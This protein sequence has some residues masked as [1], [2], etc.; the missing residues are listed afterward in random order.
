MLIIKSSTASQAWRESFLRLINE[1]LETGNQKY[2]RDEPAVIEI[3]R[4][5]LEKADPLFP[6]SQEDLDIINSFIWSG[7]NEAE[8]AHE[9]TKLYYHRAFDQPN[10][11]VEYLLEKV[12]EE[13]P[14][15][16]AQISMWDKSVDQTADITPCTQIVWARLKHGKLEV[17]VHAH[18]S[19]AYKKL[20][21][22]L[23]EFIS[24]QHYLAGRL[25]VEVG[26]YYHFLDSCHLHQ[27]DWAEIQKL[28]R[29][30]N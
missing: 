21:M 19:D 15:G 9:W 26:A 8:V 1:G 13:R 20:F 16:D 6:M 3:E 14:Q 24:L 28:A 17:H 11:Q 5:I 25:N 2:F 12:R 18:S 7:Q 23:Q 22:N 27:K 4:P 10:S 29:D 30:L